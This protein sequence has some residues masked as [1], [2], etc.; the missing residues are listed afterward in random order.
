MNQSRKRKKKIFDRKW[1]MG[2]SAPEAERGSDGQWWEQLWQVKN[3]Y[4]KIK[5]I[6]KKNKQL[7]QI[8]NQ[9]WSKN[10]DNINQFWT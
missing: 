4:K 10:N 6:N 5:C 9:K 2:I 3:R 8:V 7:Q 1:L